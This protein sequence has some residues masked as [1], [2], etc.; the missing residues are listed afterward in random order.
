MQR[1]PSNVTPPVHT[2]LPVGSLVQNSWATKSV[3]LRS[4]SNRYSRS[5]SVCLPETWSPNP[6]REQRTYGNLVTSDAFG[7]TP[8]VNG[9]AKSVKSFEQNLSESESLVNKMWISQQSD[10][11]NAYG[12]VNNQSG[13]SGSNVA[14]QYDPVDTTWSNYAPTPASGAQSRYYSSTR[15]T[16]AYTSVSC[17]SF[18]L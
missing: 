7:S 17:F 13:A 6:T 16:Y 8:N 18:F 10:K 11:Q 9:D 3:N 14:H 4:E 15:S 1:K 2:P 5:Q 12:S